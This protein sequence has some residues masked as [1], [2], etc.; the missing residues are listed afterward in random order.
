MS[1]ITT[2]IGD[3]RCDQYRWAHKKTYEPKLIPGLKKRWCWVD[4]E[5]F[6]VKNKG[7]QR[8]IRYEYWAV[9]DERFLITHYCGDESIY[10]PFAH[11][12]ATTEK[13]KTFPF[14][15]VK[16]TVA[17]EILQQSACESS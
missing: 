13:G 15:R 10:R 8:F 6:D 2:N 12:A 14:A 11:R 17:A 16:S 4:S 5:E 1:T 9:D 3:F 7:D